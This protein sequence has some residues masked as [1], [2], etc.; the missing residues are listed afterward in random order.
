A[1]A[2]QVLDAEVGGGPQQVLVGRLQAVVDGFVEA[3]GPVGVGAEPR[4]LGRLEDGRG[5]RK[6]DGRGARE[7]VVDLVVVALVRRLV[8]LGVGDGV[9]GPAG[10][11]LEAQAV[12]GQVVRRAL[13]VAGRGRV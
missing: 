9:A 3:V 13:G 10:L 7:V 1:L 6:A 4:V 8:H 11:V 2:V 12:A 5:D